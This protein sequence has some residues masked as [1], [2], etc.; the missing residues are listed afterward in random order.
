M[1]R[2]RPTQSAPRPPRHRPRVH[3]TRKRA[4]RSRLMWLVISGGLVLALIGM[5][6]F[7]AQN[8]ALE[9]SAPHA[10]APTAETPLRTR[11]VFSR[12]RTPITDA[13]VTPTIFSPTETV[14]MTTTSPTLASGYLQTRGSQIVDSA[15]NIVQ[16][17]GINWFG[18]ETERMSPGG[19]DLRTLDSIMSQIKTLGYN[20]VRLP[21]SSAIFAPEAAPT[22]IDPTLNPDLVG[23]APLEI[24]D[25]VVAVAR[26]YGLRVILD[27]HRPSSSAQSA[28]WY[29]PECPETCWLDSLTR[30][31]MRYKGNPTVIGL[32][33]HNEPHEPATWGT[34]DLA[35]DWRLAAERGGSAVLAVNPDLLIFVEG[36]DWGGDLAMVRT[37]P[38]RLAVPNRVVYAPHDYPISVHSRPYYNDPR[39]PG[40]LPDVWDGRWGY[41]VKDNIAPVWIGEFGTFNRIA[42][43]RQWFRAITGYIGQHGLNFAYWCLNPNSS[44]TGGILQSDWQTVEQEKQD[45]LRPI[46]APPLT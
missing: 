46:L 33:L 5:S 45:I 31:A 9:T 28:L 6:V 13:I 14:N 34:N 2:K 11:G 17:T 1:N 36:L 35:T 29:T 41:L 8:A 7:L 19:L 21:Y 10:D 37:A 26:K 23:L 40:N 42:A 44:D 22:E 27:R 18:M 38:V 4:P 39:Y 15:G 16:L 12:Q 3:A 20:S 25:R 24:M 43:D 32:D 30:L